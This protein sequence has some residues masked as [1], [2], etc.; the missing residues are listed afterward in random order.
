MYEFRVV[1]T[2]DSNEIL[3]LLKQFVAVPLDTPLALI[4]ALPVVFTIIS[5][6]L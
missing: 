3:P 4:P 5:P 1:V 2:L 6:I